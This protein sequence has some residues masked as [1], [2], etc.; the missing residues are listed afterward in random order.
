MYLSNGMLSFPHSSFSKTEI[1]P[2]YIGHNLDTRIFRL[3]PFSLGS[4]VSKKIASHLALI[5][6]KYDNVTLKVIVVY[7]C[8]LFKKM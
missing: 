1:H 7:L 8:P 3:I 5:K 4:I 6:S 2:T